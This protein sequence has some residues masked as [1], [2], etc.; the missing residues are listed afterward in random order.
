VAKK[1]GVT[2]YF[3]GGPNSTNIIQA[4]SDLASPPAW[5]NVSTNVADAGGGWQFGETNATNSA[6]FY[7]SYAP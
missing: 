2:L 3:L 5:R 1:L 7:R 4:A 6:R